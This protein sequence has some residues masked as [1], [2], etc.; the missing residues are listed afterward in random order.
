MLRYPVI[1]IGMRLN[2]FHNKKNLY[3][4]ITLYI[5]LIE[6]EENPCKRAIKLKISF[7]YAS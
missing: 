6:T 7:I 2:Y 5:F 3:V 1:L 4:N